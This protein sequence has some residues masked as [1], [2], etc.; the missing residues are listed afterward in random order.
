MTSR[1]LLMYL[2]LG[3]CTGPMPI[4]QFGVPSLLL[5][6]PTSSWRAWKVTVIASRV[7][8]KTCVRSDRGHQRAGRRQFPSCAHPPDSTQEFVKLS[9]SFN[10]MAQELKILSFW[11]SDFINNFS[12]EFKTPIVFPARGFAKILKSDTPTRRKGTNIRISL[13][14]SP[15]R[16]GSTGHQ[17]AGICPR[18]RIPAFNEYQSALN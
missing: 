8:L 7:P 11:C 4:P 6:S 12:H 10:R 14:A 2:Y 5:L 3:F 17:R 9:E 16:S 13:S 1:G 15:T 18:W